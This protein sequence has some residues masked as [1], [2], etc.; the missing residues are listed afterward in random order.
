MTVH[1]YTVVYAYL[2]K[3]GMAQL[4]YDATQATSPKQA[5]LQLATDVPTV[6]TDA[7]VFSGEHYDKETAPDGEVEDGLSLA[8][9]EPEREGALSA[10]GS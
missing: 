4:Y 1:T 10:S 9:N 5:A 6:P 3:S 7:L 2:D 8:G